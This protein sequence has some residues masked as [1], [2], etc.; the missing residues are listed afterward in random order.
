M[1]TATLEELIGY[2]EE[3]FTALKKATPS[4]PEWYQLADMCIG[5]MMH[6]YIVQR[7]AKLADQTREREFR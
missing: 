5:V 6:E 4:S 2:D 1:T 3:L 7:K